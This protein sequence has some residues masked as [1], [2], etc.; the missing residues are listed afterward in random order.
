MQM[1]IDLNKYST[2]TVVPTVV[3]QPVGDSTRYSL[4]CSQMSMFHPA[5]LVSMYDGSAASLCLQT[6]G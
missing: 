4:L 2:T 5:H 3:I 6:V 1:C